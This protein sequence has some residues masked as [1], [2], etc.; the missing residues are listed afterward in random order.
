MIVC[1]AQGGGLGHLTRIRAYLHTRGVAGEPVTILTGSPFAGDPRVVAGHRVLSAPAGLD[2]DGLARWIGA[3]LAGLRPREF[4]VDAFPAGLSG[5]LSAAVVPPGTRV[6]HLA[7]LL[8]WD[9]YRPLLAADP[10][11]FAETRLVEPV[12]GEHRAYLE[13]VSSAVAPLTLADPPEPE[14]AVAVAPGGWLIVHSGPPA[15]VAELVAYALDVAAI[16]GTRPGF[17]LVSPSRP[18]V[19]PPGVAHHD[20]YPA[21]PLFA[22]ADRVVTAAGC[23]AVRQ[24]ARWP[25]RHRMLPFPRRFDD[26][27][28]RAARAR[29]STGA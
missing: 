3:T 10:L 16:E 24:L 5:E 6:V 29:A 7:R 25:E 11:E 17:T 15:E 28:A 26:Q 12:G 21:W 14:P 23:N 18:D 13:A 27:Y 1:Y 19:L 8:R 2:R 20:A 9:A 22:R 4:V